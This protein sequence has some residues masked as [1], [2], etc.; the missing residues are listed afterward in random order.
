MAH[1]GR[2][3]IQESGLGTS[4]DDTPTDLRGSLGLHPN[5]IWLWF[6]T[7]LFLLTKNDMDGLAKGA[8]MVAAF[9]PS[10]GLNAH[11][12][13]QAHMDTH[14]STTALYNRLW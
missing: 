2:V 9:I 4:A 14:A 7:V 3:P 12:H 10:I 8:G 13:T 6:Q 5:F 11:R 1:P